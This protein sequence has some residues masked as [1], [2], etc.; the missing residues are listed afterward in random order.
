MESTQETQADNQLIQLRL[1]GQ[2]R[3]AA[4]KEAQPMQRD[5]ADILRALIA[6]NGGKILAKDA[7]QKCTSQNPDSPNF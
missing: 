2:L 7:R 1:I 6:A 5:R 4:K 3:D